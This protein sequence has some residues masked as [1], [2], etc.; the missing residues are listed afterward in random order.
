MGAA[1]AELADHAY[2]TSDNPGNEDPGAVLDD[3]VSGVDPQRPRTVE[4]AR[5][6]AIRLALRDARDGDTVLVAGKGHETYQE[7]GGRMVHFDDR[8]VLRDAL[9][10]E[11]G[12]NRG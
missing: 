4:P 10:A 5:A 11:A 12:E 2:V 9:A 7:T 1:V 8:E 3:I 6:A